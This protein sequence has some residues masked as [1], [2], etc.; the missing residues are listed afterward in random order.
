[1]AELDLVQIN[2]KFDPTVSSLLP[3]DLIEE[4][5]TEILN[6]YSDIAVGAFQSK[7]PVRTQQ[8]RNLIKRDLSSSGEARVYVSDAAH[9]ESIYPTIGGRR[10]GRYPTAAEVAQDLDEGPFHRRSN[11]V[12]AFKNFTPPGQGEPTA[13]WIDDAFNDLLGA[14]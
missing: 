6:E 7:V 12:S 5:T 3:D 10:L 9:T 14:L 4:L 8:L 2:I 11:A 1:M 13:N